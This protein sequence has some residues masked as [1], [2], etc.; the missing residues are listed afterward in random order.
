MNILLLSDDLRTGK[1]TG[2]NIRLLKLIKYISRD[3]KDVRFDIYTSYID[4]NNKI[5]LP[6]CDIHYV[7][8]KIYLSVTNSFEKRKNIL[9]KIIWKILTYPGTTDYLW[10]KQ[11]FDMI[12]RNKDKRNYDLMLLQVPSY[13]N[14]IYGIILKN[15][16][17]IP[18]IYDLRDDFSFF[19]SQGYSK[20]L[21]SFLLERKMIKNAN[22]IVCVTLASLN[23]LRKKYQYFSNKLFYIPNGY[24]PEDFPKNDI[25]I[26]YKKYHGVKTV[27]YGGAVDNKRIIVF[28]RLLKVLQ[29]IN[30]NNPSFSTKVKFHFYTEN[31]SK[32]ERLI[33]KY[34]LE[35]MVFIKSP[36]YDKEKYYTLLKNAD[37]LL[38][39]N[40]NTPYCIPGK[41]Y[42]YLALNSSVIHI[43]T[44]S[45]TKEVLIYSSNSKLILM[46]DIVRLEDVFMNLQYNSENWRKNSN[47]KK[48]Y[49]KFN[50]K[51]IANDY[52]NI[53]SALC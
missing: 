25:L 10:I 43:D 12:I 46:D 24:D 33:H 32:L 40:Y 3:H 20:F 51:T 45:I 1:T 34:N 4:K 47:I 18:L 31:K 49:L 27:V 19:S 8:S 17:K 36:I 35:K 5:D 22:L 37:M 23:K 9:K 53:I 42:E 26:N 2:G 11:A 39:M 13:L 16:L 15:K 7:K 21:I 30:I 29:E 38:S 50:R 44:T 52:Y 14:V 41:L 48:Y 6:G 28:D